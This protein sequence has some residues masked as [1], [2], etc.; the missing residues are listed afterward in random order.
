MDFISFAEQTAL[1]ASQLVEHA[2]TT[3]ENAHTTWAQKTKEYDLKIHYLGLQREM[4]VDLTPEELTFLASGPPADPVLPETSLEEAL[5][6]GDYIRALNRNAATENRT[7]GDRVRRIIVNVSSQ[8]VALSVATALSE[9]F[10]VPEISPWISGY[11]VFLATA[12]LSTGIKFDKIIVYYT[13]QQSGDGEDHLGGLIVSAIS[14]AIPPDAAVDEFGP[15]YSPLAPGIAWAEDPSTVPGLENLSFSQTRINAVNAVI[16]GH[17]R[18]PAFEEFVR[19]VAERMRETN[20]DPLFPHR[21]LDGPL[22]RSPRPSSPGPA[23]RRHDRHDPGEPMSKVRRTKP[24]T[25]TTAIPP[26]DPAP[27]VPQ[28]QRNPPRPRRFGGPRDLDT[29]GIAPPAAPGPG[30]GNPPLPRGFNGPRNLNT[31]LEPPALP[32]A[33]PLALPLA[34]PP[35]PADP[36]AQARPQAIG[37]PRLLRS[38]AVREPDVPAPAVPPQ[39]PMPTAAERSAEALQREQRRREQQERDRLAESTLRRVYHLFYD[40]HGDRRKDRVLPDLYSDLTGGPSSYTGVP[41]TQSMFEVFSE[42][43]SRTGTVSAQNSSILETETLHEWELSVGWADRLIEYFLLG[44]DLSAEEVAFLH[45]GTPPYPDIPDIAAI[46]AEGDY[47]HVHNRYFTHKEELATNL[48]RIIVNVTSQSAALA[49]AAALSGL[50]GR[51]DVSPWL[52]EHKLFLTTAAN[53]ND[54][55]KYDKVVVYYVPQNRL[56]GEDLI[57][58]VVVSTISAAMPTGAAVDEFGPFYSRIAPGI[59]WAEDPTA[60]VKAFAGLSFSQTRIQAV[61][62]VIKTNDHIESPEAFLTLVYTTL[63]SQG[64]DPTDPHRHLGSPPT[65]SPRPSRS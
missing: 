64:I 16:L 26:R 46:L 24:K 19:L 36:D 53:P 5:A 61:T 44:G 62:S 9:L 40:G 12:R 33:L 37:R 21:H 18:I 45:K 11:K 39:I 47:F 38:P 8:Q 15:F 58:G 34:L 56:D 50:Y 59:A 65:S 55:I 1:V 27:R 52:Y 25:G 29:R 60:F 4:D 23:D 49:I 10:G 43:A 2:R 30:T 7:S 20:I 63:Q 54:D 32:P 28:E 31:R 51:A 41:I 6:M 13:P 3:A 17:R 42:T 35:A 14:G 57:G 48:R 22:D